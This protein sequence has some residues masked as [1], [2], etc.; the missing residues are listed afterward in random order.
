MESFGFHK[1]ILAQVVQGT[2]IEYVPSRGL[3][4]LIREEYAP[5]AYAYTNCATR[6]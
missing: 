5:K 4:P 6:A 3:E 1:F 2:A